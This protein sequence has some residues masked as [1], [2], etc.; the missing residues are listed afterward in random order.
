MTRIPRTPP[1]RRAALRLLAVLLPATV[2][3]ACGRKGDLEKPSED[4]GKGPTQ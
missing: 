2:L 4:A 3:A 1:S